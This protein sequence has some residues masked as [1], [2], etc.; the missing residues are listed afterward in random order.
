[1]FEAFGLS[2][3]ASRLKRADLVERAVRSDSVLVRDVVADPR[4]PNP[5]LGPT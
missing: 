4:W 1:L 3:S 2:G 5:A